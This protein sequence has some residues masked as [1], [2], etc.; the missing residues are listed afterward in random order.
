M[1]TLCVGLRRALCRPH[2]AE[3][4]G[5]CGVKTVSVSESGAARAAPTSDTAIAALPS[6]KGELFVY[7][8]GM[9]MVAFLATPSTQARRGVVVLVPGL[10]DGLLCPR[11]YA[12]DLAKAAVAGGW[13]FVQPV[14]SSSYLGYGTASLDTDVDELDTLLDSPQ[15]ANDAAVVLV[16]HSTG[17][18]DAVH[19][20]KLGRHRQRVKCVILQAPCS[21]REAMI[22]EATSNG[23]LP[24]LNQSIAAAEASVADGDGDQLMPRSTPGTYGSPITAERFHSLSGRMT[25]DDMFS[26]DLTDV[27]LATK[28]GHIGDVEC[29]LHVVYSGSDEFQPSHID[30]PAHAARLCAASRSPQ[31]SWAIIEGASHALDHPDHAAK[32]VALAADAISTL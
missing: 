14:L 22:A 10:T 5:S 18:Q 12:A 17:C 2:S 20:L 13:A 6:V 4:S 16:G 24:Q 30:K 15:L 25:V 1:F 8:T 11:S 32:F 19:Y 28:L 29:K 31:A 9:T 26:S 21:D 23:S 3:P 7:K 27:E